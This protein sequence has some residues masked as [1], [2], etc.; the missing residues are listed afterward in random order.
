L[1][2]DVMGAVALTA[3]GRRIEDVLEVT[4]RPDPGDAPPPTLGFPERALRVT[5]LSSRRGARRGN[6]VG[7]GDAPSEM[8]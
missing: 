6:C 7:V 8:R 2:G 3:C 1:V 4:P 5:C